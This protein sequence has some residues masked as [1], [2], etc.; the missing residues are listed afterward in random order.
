VNSPGRVVI[1]QRR[2]K[3]LRGPFALL[4]NDRNR[5]HNMGASVFCKAS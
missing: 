3:R 4:S 5:F 1:F 2:K